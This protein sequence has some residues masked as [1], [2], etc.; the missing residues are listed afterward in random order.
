MRAPR[1]NATPKWI[2]RSTF[3]EK[4]PLCLPSIAPA[5]RFTLHG[6]TLASVVAGLALGE[7]H[8]AFAAAASMPVLEPG[9]GWWRKLIGFVTGLWNHRAAP[10]TPPASWVAFR[11]GSVTLNLADPLAPQAFVIGQ[12]V[13][14]AVFADGTKTT[15]GIGDSH[16]GARHVRVEIVPEQ[17]ALR[18]TDCGEGV[19]RV[20][21]TTLCRSAMM[22][23]FHPQ[24]VVVHVHCGKT[25]IAIFPPP[26]SHRVVVPRPARGGWQWQTVFMAP[27]TSPLATETALTEAVVTATQCRDRGLVVEFARDE[28]AGTFDLRFTPAETQHHGALS[29]HIPDAGHQLQLIK[30]ILE[31]CVVHVQPAR[32]VAEP[33]LDVLVSWHEPEE[34]AIIAS[35]FRIEDSALR[36]EILTNGVVKFIDP[37]RE[38]EVTGSAH[39]E[40]R[41]GVAGKIQRRYLVASAKQPPPRL[42]RAEIYLPWNLNADTTNEKFLASIERAHAAL[43]AMRAPVTMQAIFRRVLE[44]AAIIRR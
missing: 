6:L 29:V 1:A 33:T 25:A 26:R 28:T 13:E 12:H 16:L 9:G 31:A 43:V 30:Q 19:T 23:H 38:E 39:F 44:S 20:G 8:L 2:D 11:D 21:E 42:P 5:A 7:S 14:N 4:M 35:L 22:I 36:G 32:P 37:A 27:L 15:V 3:A 10:R 18:I 41:N 34:M 40:Y 17:W 24:T